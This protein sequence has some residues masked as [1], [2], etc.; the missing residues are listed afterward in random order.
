MKIKALTW[1]GA[2]A[3]ASSGATHAAGESAAGMQ[4]KEVSRVIAAKEDYSSPQRGGFQWG[5]DN[6]S[7]P[8][9]TKKWAD[10]TD[11]SSSYSWGSKSSDAIDSEHSSV[12]EAT[13]AATAIQ[14]GYRW[15]I[16]N[17]ADQAG[18]RWGIR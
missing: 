16:R 4:Y 14:T 18:Y 8:A 1:I 3:I 13:N 12:A 5:R 15:G 9:P 11:P 7:A 2:I 6:Q 17:D 10:T